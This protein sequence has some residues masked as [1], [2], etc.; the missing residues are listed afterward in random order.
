V[1]RVAQVMGGELGWNRRQVTREAERWREAVDEESL[2]S[3]A[4]AGVR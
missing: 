3:A 1:K 4:P 2:V